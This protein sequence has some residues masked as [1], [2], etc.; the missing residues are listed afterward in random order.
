[1][2]ILTILGFL[3]LS[4]QFKI[5]A[6]FSWILKD[7]AETYFGTLL[8]GKDHYLEKKMSELFFSVVII[9]QFLAEFSQGSRNGAHL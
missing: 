1:M 2:N 5:M 9:G 8:T 3:L 6:F 4:C 7:V